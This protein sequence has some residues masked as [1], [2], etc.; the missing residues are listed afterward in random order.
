MQVVY[1]A[2][3]E[4]DRTAAVVV[5]VKESDHAHDSDPV[6]GALGRKPP[7][8]GNLIAVRLSSQASL[9]RAE[10]QFLSYQSSLDSSSRYQRMGSTLSTA[11]KWCS[12]A[13][14]AP[15][16]IQFAPAG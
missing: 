11:R 1:P 16:A 6:P 4:M 12:A 13:K 7:A 14:T 15:V 10:F 2:A 3:D 9:P 5:P 8:V